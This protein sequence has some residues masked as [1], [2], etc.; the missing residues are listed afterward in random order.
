MLLNPDTE[1][2]P[3]SI[4]KLLGFMEEH[5][6]A[7]GAGPLLVNTDGTPQFPGRRFPALSHLLWESVFLDRLF[8]RFPV[9]GDH[10]GRRRLPATPERVDFV[11]GAAL[12]LRREIA[13]EIGLLD[14]SF[15]MY[16]EEVD[17]CYRIWECGGECWL[18]PS[19]RVIHHGGVDLGHY[20]QRRLVEYHRSLLHFFEKH[21]SWWHQLLLRPLLAIRS[22]IR[23]GVWSVAPLVR[24]Q[25]RQASLSSIKGYAEVLRQLVVGG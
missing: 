20:D 15:F 8:P 19:A 2:M 7:S 25:L 21:Y 1:L 14:E 3:G 22:L 23:I 6:R 12:L 11:H 4:E 13:L 10:R 16:F 24:P 5:H 9:F 17:W 18:V